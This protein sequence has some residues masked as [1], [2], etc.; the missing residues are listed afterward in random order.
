MFVQLLLNGMELL[1][2]FIQYLV[3]FNLLFTVWKYNFNNSFNTVIITE[4]TKHLNIDKFVRFDS[5]FTNEVTH[6]NWYED[7]NV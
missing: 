6:K 3:R 7:K 1:M 5:V 4:S 2:L